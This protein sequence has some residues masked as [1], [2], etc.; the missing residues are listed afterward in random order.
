ME[1]KSASM[2]P[3]KLN[4]LEQAWQQKYGYQSYE[5]VFSRLLL[6]YTPLTLTTAQTESPSGRVLSMMGATFR[7]LARIVL[8]TGEVTIELQLGTETFASYEL[9]DARGLVDSETI[10]SYFL[11]ER[12]ELNDHPGIKRK[13]EKVCAFFL[14]LFRAI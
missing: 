8:E 3:K 12:P 1:V 9:S 14:E 5:L 6:L 10:Y 4:I 7:F 2:D 11:F 13:F